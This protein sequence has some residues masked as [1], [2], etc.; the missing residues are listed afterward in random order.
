MKKIRLILK[1]WHEI[2]LFKLVMSQSRIVKYIL[3]KYIQHKC[4]H[5]FATFFSYETFDN[6]QKCKKC[7]K[8]K[9]KQFK[10]KG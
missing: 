4:N 7:K 10:D 6:Y 2:I 8:R 1:R 3:K 9:Y 5:D